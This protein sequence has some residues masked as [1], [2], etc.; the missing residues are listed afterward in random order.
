MYVTPM[1]HSIQCRPEEWRLFG[2]ESKERQWQNYHDAAES[3][4][5]VSFSDIIED[6]QWKFHWLDVQ[7]SLVRL[8][9]S[10]FIPTS[11]CRKLSQLIQALCNS[12]K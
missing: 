8:S 1:K 7:V 11:P 3:S 12:M 9:K 10:Y 6:D 2:K 4:K 5:S